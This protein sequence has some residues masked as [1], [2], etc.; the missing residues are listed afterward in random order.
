MSPSTDDG[1]TGGPQMHLAG[2]LPASQANGW[3]SILDRLA[4]DPGVRRLAVIEYDVLRRVV[5]TDTEQIRP[6]IRIRQVEICEEHELKERA[7]QLLDDGQTARTGQAALI[8]PAS[9]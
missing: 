2:T 1:K 4:S 7:A 5:D 8:P 9:A 3:L 6:I